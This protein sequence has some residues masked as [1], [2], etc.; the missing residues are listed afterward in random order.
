MTNKIKLTQK[1][2]DALEEFKVKVIPEELAGLSTH[3]IF[4]AMR[5]GYEIEKTFEVDDWVVVFDEYV[6]KVLQIQGELVTTDRLMADYLIN[7]MT[8]SE[9]TNGF[10]HATPEEVAKEQERRDWALIKRVPGNFVTGDVLEMKSGAI[11]YV[12]RFDTVG[13]TIS[14]EHAKRA[15]SNNEIEGIFPQESKLNL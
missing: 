7:E 5:D 3:E 4:F 11:K 8:W 6:M 14:I 1:Q 2:A 10:R 13:E 12:G 15:F 9:G